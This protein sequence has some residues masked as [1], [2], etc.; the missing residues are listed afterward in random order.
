VNKIE[1]PVITVFVT[2][3]FLAEKQGFEPWL[4]LRAL[5]I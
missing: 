1:N 5:T 2:T 4:P 3:G